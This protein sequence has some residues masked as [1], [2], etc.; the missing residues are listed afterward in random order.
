MYTADGELQIPAALGIQGCL[1]D[2][3]RSREAFQSRL[4]GGVCPWP[5]FIENGELDLFLDRIDAVHQNWQALA[6][7]VG[8][9]AALANDLAGVFVIDVT[10]VGEGGEGNE[11]FNKQI[12]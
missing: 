1:A 4:S 8:F 11:T 10:I 6:E 5:A 12:R 3:V 2:K 9:G 7:A